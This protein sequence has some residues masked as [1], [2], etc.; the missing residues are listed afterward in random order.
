MMLF[1]YYLPNQKLYVKLE[2]YFSKI[3]SNMCGVPQGSI[4]APLLFFI[5]VNNMPMRVKCR[6]SFNCQ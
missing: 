4:L 6:L 5:F 2:N 3:S 1:Q